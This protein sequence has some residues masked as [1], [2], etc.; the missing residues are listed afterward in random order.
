MRRAGWKRFGNTIC[1]T[2]CPSRHWMISFSLE[3]LIYEAPISLISLID[4]KRQW[5]KSKI[6]LSASETAR[7]ISFC[8][9]AIL[10]TDL[11]A[12]PSGRGAACRRDAANHPGRA[13]RLRA[14]LVSIGRRQ[15]AP[16]VPP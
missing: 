7:A 3:A 5:F 8:G 10:Q 2:L 4:E 14:L 6:G 16:A 11:L 9:H 13:G 1:S 12:L 15:V